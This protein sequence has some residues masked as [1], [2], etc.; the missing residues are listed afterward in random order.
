MTT[1]IDFSREVNPE[2][3]GMRSLEIQELV[4][5]F[6]T[7][8]TE[9]HLHPAA[10]LVVLRHGKVVLDR[11]LGTGRGGA[12]INRDTPFYTFS[13][14]KP[15][16]GMC[17]HK[18]IEEGRVK[19]DAR[20]SDY[21]PEWGCKGKE[22]A[23]IRHAFLHQAGIPS[24]HLY[25][26]IFAWTNWSRL[27]RLI[28]NYEA[29]FTPG[30]Q[31]GYHLVNYGFILGEIV[32]RVTG[33]MVDVYFQEKFGG[34][35]G[36]QATRLRTDDAMLRQSPRLVS[37]CKEN[38]ST[39]FLFNLPSIRKALIPAASLCSNARGLAV[40]Y[41][42][43]LNGG[44]YDDRQ[45]LKPETVAGA[46]QSGYRGYDSTLRINMHYGYGFQLGGGP[47]ATPGKAIEEYHPSY[48]K[49]STGRTFGHLGLGSCMAW[50]DP[51]ADLVVAF[52]CNGL[53][54]DKITG[55]RWSEISDAVWDAVAD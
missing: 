44:E 45:L 31:T 50:A 39:A 53:H 43:L 48:G 3:A 33:Q 8:I 4:R 11:A 30:A 38:R 24:P 20:I 37:L 21:W 23:T 2:T 13:V 6:D 19:M 14:S 9:R 5:I 34:S 54:H 32:R 35:L 1:A 16:T 25:R 36:L 15:F 7:Q 29:V 41:Q 55:E 52:N 18:L 28:A 49:G 47:V 27:M 22:T 51:D 46:I 17:V 10:Q 40:F 26:Q 42:M 12:A